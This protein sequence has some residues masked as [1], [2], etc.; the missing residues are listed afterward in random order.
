MFKRLF[1]V[2]VVCLGAVPSQAMDWTGFYFGAEAGQNWLTTFNH[3]TMEPRSAENWSVGLTGGYLWDVGGG[4]L[5]GFEG[6]IGALNDGI[7]SLPPGT[8]SYHLTRVFGGLSA[9]AGLDYDRILPYASAGFRLV[10]VDI[11]VTNANPALSATI[12]GSG[13]LPTVSAGIEA[14][15]TSSLSLKAEYSAIF[16]SVFLQQDNGATSDFHPHS[17]LTFGLNYRF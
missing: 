12:K 5:L 13:V 17:A 16:G 11:G 15:L 8:V 6:E 14:S 2:G 10:S 3:I 7:T 4:T 1:L 9:R